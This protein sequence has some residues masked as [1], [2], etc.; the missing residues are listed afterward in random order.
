MTMRRPLKQVE[1]YLLLALADGPLHGYAMSS[2][3][4]DESDGRIRMLPGNLYAVIRRLT[5]AGLLV[6]TKARPADGREDQRRRFFAL[7]DTGRQLLT[8]EARR[9]ARL[10]ETVRARLGDGSVGDSEAT[11]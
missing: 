11:S 2:R 1:L 7:T 9:M 4:Q 10:A 3:I 6:E 5:G 8:D